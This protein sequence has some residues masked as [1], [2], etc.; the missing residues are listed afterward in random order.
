MDPNDFTDGMRDEYFWIFAWILS[1]MASATALL[2]I[3]D[4]HAVIAHKEHFL[5]DEDMEENGFH[6]RGWRRP[7]CEMKMKK[8]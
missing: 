4:G 5:L 2:P 6:V 3:E 8:L 7:Y 1:K